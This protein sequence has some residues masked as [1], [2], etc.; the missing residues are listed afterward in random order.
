MGR[1]DKEDKKRRIDELEM[2]MIWFGSDLPGVYICRVST[3]NFSLIIQHYIGKHPSIFT[4]ITY[5]TFDPP[6]SFCFDDVCGSG[7]INTP[8]NGLKHNLHL[9]HTPYMHN[10]VVLVTDEIGSESYN[11][12]ERVSMNSNLLFI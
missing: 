3:V 9:N 6:P 11:V 8:V 7:G 2:E 5:N 12:E 4:G 1:V 10:Y